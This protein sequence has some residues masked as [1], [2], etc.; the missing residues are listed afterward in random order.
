MRCRLHVM[1]QTPN[2]FMECIANQLTNN[3]KMVAGGT[4]VTGAEICHSVY[5]FLIKNR[6]LLEVSIAKIDM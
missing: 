3:P 4:V 2:N 1:A 6:T 5:E